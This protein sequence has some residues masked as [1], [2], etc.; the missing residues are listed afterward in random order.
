MAV[1]GT[2]QFIRSLFTDR[3]LI[4]KAGYFFHGCFYIFQAFVDLCLV[5]GVAE[6]YT[7]RSPEP[8]SQINYHLIF[9]EECRKKFPRI[10]TLGEYIKGA[11]RLP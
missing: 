2:S 6:P 5:K 7:V 9:K 8:F 1:S 10:L 3:L 4:L 11:F